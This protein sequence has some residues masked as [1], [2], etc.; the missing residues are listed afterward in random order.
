MS[1]SGECLETPRNRVLES[2][3]LNGRRD[4][5]RRW[6]GVYLPLSLYSPPRQLFI[7]KWMAWKNKIKV[8]AL[9]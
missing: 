3:P 7:D 8:A 2:T 4:L 1:E 5:R 9:L 6:R